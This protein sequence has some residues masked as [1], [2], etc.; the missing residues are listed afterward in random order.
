MKTTLLF[1]ACKIKSKHYAK[2][3]VPS[4]T[5]ERK[6]N[7]HL[8]ELYFACLSPEDA[9]LNR[10]SSFFFFSFYNFWGRR[11]VFKHIYF[12]ARQMTSK[13]LITLS[14]LCL[15]I[16]IVKSFSETRLYWFFFPG[17]KNPKVMGGE[18][19]SNHYHGQD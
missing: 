7:F 14:Q 5:L 18:K 19:G 10:H 9:T 3:Y 12:N 4:L 13:F 11:R 6:K 15:V 8:P 2:I 17:C 16:P 1:L